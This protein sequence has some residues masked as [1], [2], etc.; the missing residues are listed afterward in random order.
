MERRVE[1]AYDR[2]VARV[3]DV[4]G[5][6]LGLYKKPQMMRR[7]MSLMRRRGFDDFDRFLEA[8]I[9]DP[10]LRAEFVD[11]VTINV[12]EFFRNPELWALLDREVLASLS[13][14]PK[15][16]LWSAACSTGEEPYT[17]LML[18]RERRSLRGVDLLATDIDEPALEKAR[19]ARYEARSLVS[20]PP[21]FRERYFVRD[22]DGYRVVDEL[23][24]AVRFVR[25]DL[26]RDPYPPG[27][28]DVIVNRNV[29]IYFTEDGKAHLYRSLAAVLRPGGYLFVGGTEQIF[30]P[31]RYGLRQVYPFIYQKQEVRP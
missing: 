30:S 5:I 24:Q 17:L 3:R 31:E 20:V 23:V 27:P 26:L 16:R 8:L 10:K 19:A 12:S 21:S 13:A 11:R 15:L 28:F 2:F 4:F 6:E 1:E 22:G 14:Q 9:A 25:H 29:A 18:L 7:L